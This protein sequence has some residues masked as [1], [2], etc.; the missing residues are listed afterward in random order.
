MVYEG[1]DIV[2]YFIDISEAVAWQTAQLGTFIYAWVNNHVHDNIHLFVEFQCRVSVNSDGCW[3]L[4]PSVAIS[5]CFLCYV[6]YH[7]FMVQLMPSLILSYFLILNFHVDPIWS[8]DW[9]LY[10]SL[11]IESFVICLFCSLCSM[12]CFLEP[13]FLMLLNTLLWALWIS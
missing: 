12:F 4:M 3:Y 11:L 9:L 8:F 10:V 2:R 1:I 6:L 5:L 13:I 7:M